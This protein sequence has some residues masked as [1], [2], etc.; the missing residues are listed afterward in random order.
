MFIPSL[1][2]RVR[3]SLLAFDNWSLCGPTLL[4]LRVG[5]SISERYSTSFNGGRHI[6]RGG[7][8]QYSKMLGLDIVAW[9]CLIV[10]F[11][12]RVQVPHGTALDGLA[13]TVDSP[14]TDES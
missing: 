12:R 9:G 8:V 2:V 11:W 7:A 13:R 6:Y 3:R 4:P 14:S 5:S 10:R 1:P